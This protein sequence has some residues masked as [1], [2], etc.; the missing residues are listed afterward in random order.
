MRGQQINRVSNI[1]LVVLSLAVLLTVLPTA[2]RAVLTGQMP[3]PELD[4]G[5]GAHIFQLSI[6]ALCTNPGN[7][8]QY[9]RQNGPYK[10]IMTTTGD[11]KLVVVCFQ[12]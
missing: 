4:E 12:E 1:G 2:L 11:S 10:L 9:K 5:T 8:L 6:V 3:T 7:R